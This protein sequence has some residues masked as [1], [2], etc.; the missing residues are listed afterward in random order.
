M[1]VK[2]KM[3]AIADAIR[4]KTGGTDSLTLDA[5]AEAIAGIEAGGGGGE[6]D[7][8]MEDNIVTDSLTEY[9]NPRVTKLGRYVFYFSNIKKHTFDAVLTK[10][11]GPFRE[12]SVV[13][14]NFPELVTAGED[15][16]LRCYSLANVSMPKVKELKNWSFEYCR[17]LV[18]LDFP[19]LE[20]I[21]ANVFYGSALETLIIRTN[22]VC[23][24]G[25]TN[26]FN[27]ACNVY[28]PQALI[29]EYQ[30][31]TNWSSL[32]ADGTLNFVAI[33]GSEYE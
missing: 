30:Q 17:E 7:Y 13:T 14:A 4:E 2:S 9:R 19:C 23:A 6:A 20:K 27:K 24:L 31:A 29:S 16:F 1:S 8:S 33:E 3:T 15:M 25:N 26:S 10:D 11:V 12:S 22:N 5:M 28:V 18:F 32:Y 21:G